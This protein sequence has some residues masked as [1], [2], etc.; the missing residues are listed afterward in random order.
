MKIYSKKGDTGKTDFCTGKRVP[1]NCLGIKA[2]GAI[3]ELNSLI[4]LV[5]TKKPK[6]ENVKI[7]KKIQNDMHRISSEIIGLNKKG[8]KI[9]KKDTLLLEQKID[10]L[11]KQ[12]PKLNKFIL[13]GGTEKGALLHYTRVICRKTERKLI[14]SENSNETKISTELKAYINRL[15]DLLF[16][17]ARFENFKT[18][19]EEK[20]PDY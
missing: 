13:P 18:G 4:G 6:Q 15:S 11:Q 12:I 19:F 3:D 9:T 1:K 17:M 10:F 14:D 5:L 7:L 20:N 16:V 8:S 2:L